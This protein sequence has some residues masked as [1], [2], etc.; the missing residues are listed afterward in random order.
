MED[1]EGVEVPE[2][3]LVFD[4]THYPSEV[5]DAAAS[6][7]GKQVRHKSF[8]VGQVVDAERTSGKTRL[9]IRFADG[10]EKKVVSAYVEF[11]D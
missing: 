9:T 1:S 6:Q 3:G 5:F 2:A 11:L 10:S 4:D 8:G 7:V